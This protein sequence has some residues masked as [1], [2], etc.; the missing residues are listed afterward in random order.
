MPHRSESGRTGLLYVPATALTALVVLLS[1]DAAARAGEDGVADGGEAQV[2]Q[3]EHNLREMRR[4][5]KNTRV[6]VLDGGRRTAAELVSEPLFRFSDE[7]RDIVDATFWAWQVEGRPVAVQKVEIYRRRGLQWFYFLASLADRV[8][9]VEWPDGQ[10]WTAKKPGLVV[11]PLPGGPQPERT[12]A[13][14]LLQLRRLARRFE[15]T[16]I[17]RDAQFR[18]EMR[19]L[20]RPIHRY[21][22]P[23]SGV[24]DGAAFGFTIGTNPDALLLIELRQTGDSAPEWKYGLVQMTTGELRV[25]LDG[26]EVWSAP[27]HKPARANLPSKFD[28][29]AFFWE[30]ADFRAEE[31]R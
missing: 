9:E 25:R 12:E 1:P 11:G 21:A 4:R 6:L 17:D 30:A 18:D 7:R 22:D 26:E 16:L 24:R 13:G 8:I 29:W 20:P 2:G 27:Y 19:L 14:L 15:A 31:P 3:R 28:T 23:A 5:A 10:Q